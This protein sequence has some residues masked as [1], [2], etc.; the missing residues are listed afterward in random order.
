MTGDRNGAAA[1]AVGALL[2]QL[3]FRSFDMIGKTLRRKE[4]TPQNRK[5]I[6]EI[7]PKLETAPKCF[8]HPP[9]F[10]TKSS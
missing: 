5:I 10:P 8:N 7:I 3:M 2:K 9:N 4:P 6:M 1:M